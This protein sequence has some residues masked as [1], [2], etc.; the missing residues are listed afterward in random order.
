MARIQNPT[1]VLKKVLDLQDPL[2]QLE[3]QSSVFP[4]LNLEHFL[5]TE[6]LSPPASLDDPLLVLYDITVL[7][8]PD[9]TIHHVF[10]V[11]STT[12]TLD[13]DQTAQLQ[14]VVHIPGQFAYC[15]GPKI[16]INA[17]E[18]GGPGAVFSEPH[19]LS[20]GIGIGVQLVG[21]A[22]GAAGQIEAR[23]AVQRRAIL[24]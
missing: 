17:L 2:D 19:I 6:E 21:G 11:M 8:V 18:R 10:S 7:R 14:L 5:F 13:A 20:A 15:F 1:G 3:F 9:G 24:I 12:D 4:V 23:I 22:L 16:T